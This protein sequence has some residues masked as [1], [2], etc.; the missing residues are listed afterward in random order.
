MTALLHQ[1]GKLG[2]L[3]SPMSA[4][5]PKLVRAPAASLER[6]DALR[7]HQRRLRIILSVSPQPRKNRS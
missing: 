5:L 3:L 6:E 7:R 1:F 2:S 4:N